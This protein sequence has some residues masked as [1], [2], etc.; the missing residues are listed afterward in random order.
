MKKLF[1]L[2][3]A[4]C[5]AVGAACA[6]DA[7]AAQT[8]VPPVHTFELGET[9]FLLDGQ[10]FVIRCGEIHYARIPRP[11]WRHRLQML[12]AMGCNAVGCYMFWNYHERAPGVRSGGEPYTAYLVS[13]RFPALNAENA[14]VMDE[15]NPEVRMY[16]EEAKKVLK[17]HFL[18]LGEEKS[19]F[20]REWEER[21]ASFS[22]EE[23]RMLYLMLKKS[24]KA[25]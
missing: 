22:K 3:G 20:E 19:E 8:V 14:L 7:A 2:L 23:R 1:L 4:A 18:A 11:Y 16:I 12:R 17:A 13:P 25:R 5:L 10:P 15:L 6:D 21:I 24:L 9:D